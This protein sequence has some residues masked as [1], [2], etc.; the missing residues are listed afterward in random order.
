MYRLTKYLIC[1]C[2][3]FGIPSS[4]IAG[5]LQNEDFK[6][7]AELIAAGSDSTH[8]LNISKIWDDVNLQTLSTTVSVISGQKTTNTVAIN[9]AIP[10]TIAAD[11]LLNVDTSG[12]GI[13]ITLPNAVLS[14]GYCAYVKNLNTNAVTVTAPLAQ[15]IDGLASDTLSVQNESHLY[16]ANGGNWFIY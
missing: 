16:C 9:F 8:L 15:T 13:A 12:G 5:S 1:T 14:A 7:V 4:T 2:L 11:Y 6:T 10:L 3:L